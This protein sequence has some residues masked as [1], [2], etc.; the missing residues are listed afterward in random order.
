MSV[1]FHY[2]PGA[3]SMAV[4]IALEEAGL[5]YEAVLTS[6]DDGA[7][8]T[9]AYLQINPLGRVPAIVLDDGRPLTEAIAILTWIASQHGSALG[10]PV[11]PVLRVRAYESLSLCA[12]MLH[13]QF[14]TWLRADEGPGDDA[15]RAELEAQAGRSYVEMLAVADARL[16]DGP[17]VLGEHYSIC[18]PYLFVMLAWARHAE[19]EIGDLSHLRAFFGRMRERDAVRKTLAVEGF[20]R[21]DAS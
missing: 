1:A 19:F 6:L 21:A 20:I 3:C 2:S 15:T 9:P 11:D 17:W 18:D 7:H 8:R 14:R 10:L 5:P 16:S 12:S 4:H 13:P